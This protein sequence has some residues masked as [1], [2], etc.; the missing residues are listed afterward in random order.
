MPF[1]FWYSSSCLLEGFLYVLDFA[2]SSVFGVLT[3]TG[4]IQ[5]LKSDV[6]A[7]GK[8]RQEL[9]NGA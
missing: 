9:K 2:M 6:A 3:N 4:C 5:D 1:F 7:G 8:H